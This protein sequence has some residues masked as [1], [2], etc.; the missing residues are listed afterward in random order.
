[1]FTIRETEG[2][3]HSAKRG[4]A[5]HVD[6]EPLWV[7]P[8]KEARTCEDAGFYVVRQQIV[9]YEGI[10]FGSTWVLAG[11]V[12]FGA[13]LSQLLQKPSHVLTQNPHCPDTLLIFLDF[14]LFPAK[15]HVP[16]A[17]A[18]DDHLADQEEVVDGVERVNCSGPPHRNHG[19]PHLALQEPAVRH[20]NESGAV[21]QGLQ[22]GRYI[23]K[24]RGRGK[25]DAVRLAHLSNAVVHDVILDDAPAILCLE[26]FIASATTVDQIAADLNEFGFDPFD[27][28]GF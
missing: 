9:Y 7:N 17:G 5:P 13:R 16:V 11:F 2:F 22:F 15:S 14:A 12:T 25:N 27:C 1:L 18:G 24:V 19:S 20:R 3:Y 23:S 6:A 4:Q 28:Y 8:K 26:A 10:T 21:D